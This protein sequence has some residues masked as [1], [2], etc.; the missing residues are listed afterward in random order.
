MTPEPDSSRETYDSPLAGA[1]QFG[2]E[3]RAANAA[4]RLSDAQVTFLDT[5][6]RAD[7]RNRFLT[8]G[9]FT[10][11]GIFFTLTINDPLNFVLFALVVGSIVNLALRDWR[12]V[13]A[14]LDDGTVSAIEGVLSQPSRRNLSAMFQQPTLVM[15]GEERFHLGAEARKVI[16]GG[17]TYRFYYTPNA[18]LILGAEDAHV[19][20]EALD[21]DPVA[22]TAQDDAGR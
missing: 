14:D 8:G 22:E 21:P 10:A 6:S 3:D 17:R 9:F 12:L 20:V 16:G 5:Q 1:L 18:R 2:P 19:P 4:G 13:R 7:R 11:V 15:V